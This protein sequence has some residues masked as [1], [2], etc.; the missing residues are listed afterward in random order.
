MIAKPRLS[1][2]SVMLSD[3]DGR[4]LLVRHSYGPDCWSLPGGGIDG[5]ESAEVAARR[6]MREELGIEL[7]ALRS[8][9]TLEET[10]S[11]TFHKAYVFAARTSHEI[12]PDGREIAE[13][14]FFS[15]DTLP[16][17]IGAIARRRIKRF[18]GV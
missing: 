17:G 6:E 5:R 9:G 3:Q 13:A 12:V 14:R 18:S 7:S 16:D 2:V 11:G 15:I 1:G 8:L 10:L 4:L